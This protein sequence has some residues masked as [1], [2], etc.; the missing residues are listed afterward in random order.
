ME[1]DSLAKAEGGQPKLALLA[2]PRL[3]PSL[4]NR[5]DGPADYR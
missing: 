3:Q 2:L 5:V 4:V 1:Q